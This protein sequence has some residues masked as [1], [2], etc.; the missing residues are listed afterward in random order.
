MEPEKTQLT[1]SFYIHILTFFISCLKLSPIQSYVNILHREPLVGLGQAE[2]SMVVQESFT[3][4]FFL[5]SFPLLSAAY[6]TSTL[7]WHKSP[8]RERC[9]SKCMS[10]FTKKWGSVKLGMGESWIILGN[11]SPGSLSV[12]RMVSRG[13]YNLLS[14][15]NITS[16]SALTALSVPSI[17]K[18]L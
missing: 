16:F 15:I 2:E 13:V 1:H 11:N 14:Q 4:R 6:Q 17:L 7:L 18:L 10:Q 8:E 5:L 12:Q 3:K 9:Q